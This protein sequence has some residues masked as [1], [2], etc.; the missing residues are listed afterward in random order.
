MSHF[1]VVSCAERGLKGP[2]KS[3]NP[4]VEGSGHCVMDGRNE[5]AKAGSGRCFERKAATISVKMD[6]GK[7]AAGGE[8][9]ETTPAHKGIVNFFFE[10]GMLKRTP[11]SGFQFLRSGQESVAEH[12]YRVSLIGY[13]MARLMSGADP[14]KVLCLCLFH[15]VPEARTGDL[16]YVNKQYVEVHEQEAIDDLAA[17]LPFGEDLKTLLAEYRAQESLEARVAHDADQLDLILELKEQNDLGNVYANQWIHFARKRLQTDM[18][19][20]LAAQILAT[21]STDWWFEGHDHW[22]R[23]SQEG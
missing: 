17:T 5:P 6:L 18:G 16:N 12:S 8:A 15:D 14:F 23:P 9:G 19:R 11:R 10:L 3:Y 1:S 13:T 4:A 2:A 21:D 22:W 7:R 20:T